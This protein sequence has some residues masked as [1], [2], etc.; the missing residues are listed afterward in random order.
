ME[1]GDWRE[2]QSA[3]SKHEGGDMRRILPGAYHARKNLFIAY[4]LHGEYKELG[5]QT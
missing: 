3:V 5:A 4:S 1:A 2:A